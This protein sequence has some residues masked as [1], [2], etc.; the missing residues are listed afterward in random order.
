MAAVFAQV[1]VPCYPIHCSDRDGWEDVVGFDAV[2][3][4]SA[5]TI[6]V[7]AIPQSAVAMLK[8]THF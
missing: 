8:D 2:L 7:I 6:V 4:S 3:N 1:V 5:R